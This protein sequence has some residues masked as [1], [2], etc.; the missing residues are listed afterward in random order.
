MSRHKD[1]VTPE[2][3]IRILKR[4]GG[5]VAPQ[6]DSQQWGTCFGRLTLEHV[7]SELRMGRRAPSDEGHLVTLC[8]G[9]TEAGARAG[10]SW[11]TMKTSRSMVRAYLRGLYERD[12]ESSVLGEGPDR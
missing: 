5:C 6:V 9:H 7:K 3:R 11:N 8:E 4:D 2:L 12:D 1:P 10:R